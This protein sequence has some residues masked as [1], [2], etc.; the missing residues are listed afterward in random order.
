MMLI[1]DHHRHG[2]IPP[3]AP[4]GVPDIALP[5]LKPGELRAFDYAAMPG[6]CWMHSHVPVPVMQLLAV[7][8]T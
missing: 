2:R 6:T 4:D 3:N 5:M 7:P 8:L 1:T